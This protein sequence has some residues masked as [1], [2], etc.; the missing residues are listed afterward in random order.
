MDSDLI[1]VRITHPKVVRGKKREDL[2]TIIDF[3][4]FEYYLEAGK[5]WVD[6]EFDAL[7]KRLE[8]N[9]VKGSWDVKIEVMYPE[10]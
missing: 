10:K 8:E 9:G 5:P 3:E 6:L 7:A 4:N 2:V 1:K